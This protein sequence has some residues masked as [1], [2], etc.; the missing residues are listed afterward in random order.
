MNKN[1]SIRTNASVIFSS[2][3]SPAGIGTEFGRD[4]SG[5]LGSVEAKPHK[6]QLT[7]HVIPQPQRYIYIYKPQSS[8][9]VV[10]Q[11]VFILC[12]Y[13][14]TYKTRK[15]VELS[16]LINAMMRGSEMMMMMM[17]R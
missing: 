8:S 14:Y 6:P 15:S 7:Q 17:M 10:Y 16:V 12:D 9:R 4:N 1:P 13:A 11:E 2:P 5:A 3:K